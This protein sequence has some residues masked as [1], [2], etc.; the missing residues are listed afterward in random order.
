MMGLNTKQQ[1]LVAIYTEYQKEIPNMNAI[2]C[3][4]LGISI[5]EFYIALKK[6][7]NEGLVNNIK[8]L[9]KGNS[10]V[11]AFVV[12]NNAMMSAYGID[13]VEKKLEM[14][15]TLSPKEKV[16]KVIGKSEEFGLKHLKDFAVNIFSDCILKAFGIK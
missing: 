12:I 5:D 2:T 15:K 9:P 1:V 4:K 6:L 16:E 13:Y 3:E 14:E 10:N 11:P 8:I 7:D